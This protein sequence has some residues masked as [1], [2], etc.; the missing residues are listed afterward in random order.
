MST[1]EDSK[2]PPDCVLYVTQ[3]RLSVKILHNLYYDILGLIMEMHG[4]SNVQYQK[5]LLLTEIDC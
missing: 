4:L 2:D 3:Q 1:T 5:R